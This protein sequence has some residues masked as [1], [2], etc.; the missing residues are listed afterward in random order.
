VAISIAPRSPDARN[1]VLGIG[2][3]VFSTLIFGFSNVLVK[4]SMTEYPVGEALFIRSVAA[5]VLI[6]PFVR[7]RDL[8]AVARISPGTQLLRMTLS[9]L[10]IGCYY[11]AIASLQLADVSAFYLSSPIM[12][13]A[14]SAVALRESVDRARWLAIAVGFAGVL[15]A[16]RPSAQTVSLPACVALLGS[17]MYAVVLTTTRS[18]RRTPNRVLVA[19]QLFSVAVAGAAAMP[20]A[21]VTPTWPALLLLSVVGMISISGSILLNRA[22]QLAPASVVAPFQYASIIWAIVL[23]YAAFGDIPDLALLAGATIIIAAGLFILF[24][25][26]MAIAASPASPVRV[27]PV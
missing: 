17:A 25:E 6:A 24:R 8:M 21:W 16:L 2:L 4:W 18:L 13:T 23:G 10:E 5:L 11:W 26:R 27:K 15:V 9:A 1:H 12:L 14:L 3:V 19:T 22:L 7:L 20:F